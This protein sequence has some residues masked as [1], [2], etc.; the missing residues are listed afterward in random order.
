MTENNGTGREIQFEIVEPI[1]VITTHS[2]GWRKELNLVSWN[3]AQPKYDIRDWDPYHEHMSRGIT[4]HEKE[5]RLIFELMK[6]RRVNSRS[7]RESAL[8]EN[9]SKSLAEVDPAP[10]EEPPEED[11]VQVPSQE[12]SADDEFTC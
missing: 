5:M 12:I 2:T 10:V 11:V 1:G 7:R 3:G 8:A 6:K 4:L 9:N